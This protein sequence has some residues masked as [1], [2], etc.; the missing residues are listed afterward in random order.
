[1]VWWIGIG[2]SA[3][4]TLIHLPISEKRVQAI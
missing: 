3:F 2:V 4:S 1:L